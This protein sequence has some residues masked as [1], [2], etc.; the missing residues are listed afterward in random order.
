MK[1]SP[2]NRRGSA[3]RNRYFI[4]DNDSSNEIDV[5][6][7]PDSE[8]D[9]GVS[10]YVDVCR[11]IETASDIAGLTFYLSSRTPANLPRYGRDIVLVLLMEERYT[12]G[13][14]YHRLLAVFRCLPAR[15]VYL[16]GFPTSTKHLTY[17]AHYSYKYFQYLNSL[18]VLLRNGKLPHLRRSLVRTMNVPLGCFTRFEPAAIPM[19]ERDIDYAFL[20]S[21]TYYAHEKKW[22]QGLMETPKEFARRVM[23]ESIREISNGA[24]WRG[25]LHTTGAMQESVKNQAIYAEI[26][27]RCK[28]S[29]VPRGTCYDTYRFFESLKAG[30]VV[31]C[32]H[33]PRRWFYEGHPGITIDDWRHLPKLLDRVLA[34][35]ELQERKSRE[36]ITFYQDRC[37]EQA[38]AKRMVEFLKLRLGRSEN[39]APPRE[40][41]V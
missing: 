4:V 31:I 17:L 12:H 32:E 35:T 30:C 26:L 39:E 10:F 14:Y 37:S 34:D 16:N 21:L 1:V 25:I 20:G 24:R 40:H 23:C 15:P 28:V 9:G 5:F 29:L 41:L 27:P 11:H 38:V 18:L 22:F 7:S 33:L 13:A 2:V 8:W 6:A 3:Q 36:A 19:R